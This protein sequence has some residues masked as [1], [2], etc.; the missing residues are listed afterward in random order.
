MD[1][2]DTLWKIYACFKLFQKSMPM[3]EFVSE[4]IREWVSEGKSESKVFKSKQNNT[5]A[6][7]QK[8]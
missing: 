5:V 8:N 7:Y 1:H 2:K 3:S 6:S 4:R